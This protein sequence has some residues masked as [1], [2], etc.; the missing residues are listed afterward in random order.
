MEGRRHTSAALINALKYAPAPERS[1]SVARIEEKIGRNLPDNLMMT[2]GQVQALR[3]AGMEIGGHTVS[4]PI[5]ARLDAREARAEI[6]AGKE[7][8]EQLL[9]EKVTLFAYPNGRP[10]Q[11]FSAEHVRLVP[12]LGFE[13]A[14]T[15]AWGTADAGTDRYQLPRFTPWDRTPLRFV[16]RMIQNARRRAVDITASAR[17]LRSAPDT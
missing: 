6:A 7:R 5:L 14:V 8:I 9:G 17:T 16:G 15:T 1:A 11:D 2:S 12:Q 4:H 10:Y 3:R 13:A